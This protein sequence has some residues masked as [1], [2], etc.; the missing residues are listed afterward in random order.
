MLPVIIVSA[1]VYIYAKIDVYRD[2][3]KY[4][5]YSWKYSFQ[6]LGDV[7]T[8]KLLNS[9]RRYNSFIFGSSRSVSVY[10]CYLQ[11]KISN[12]RFFHYGSYLETVGGIYQKLKLLDSLG[13]NLNNIY[14]YIDTDFTFVK[15]GK[16]RDN[17]HY[18]ITGENKY[19]YYLKHF[20][21]FYDSDIK[22]KIITGS[23]LTPKDYPGWESDLVTNDSRHTCSDSILKSY[24]NIDNSEKQSNR[25]ELLK[26]SGI[27]KERSNVQEYKHKQISREEEELLEKIKAILDRHKS[28]YYIII[29]P[30]YDQ[31]K[32]NAADFDILKKIFGNNVYDFSGIND[33]TNDENN[34]TDGSHF[35]YYISKK[36]IDSVIV[37]PK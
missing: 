29:T 10:A 17:D 32:I 11:T 25:V 28:N 19:S 23:K 7:S 16:P 33:I 31:K 15:D 36:I 21:S 27:L 34:Y 24:G 12:S 5:N 35:Q 30:L 37:N 20:R 4:D 9:E 18:L 6:Q 26:K 1:A 8:K 3:G 14:I 22:F 2:F 13:Y